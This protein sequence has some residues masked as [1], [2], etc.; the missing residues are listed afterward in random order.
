[1][2]PKGRFLNL[3]IKMSITY[4]IFQGVNTW[5]NQMKVQKRI[6]T[7]NKFKMHKES[8]IIDMGANKITI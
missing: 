4:L 2:L 8:F 7:N 1:M 6:Y 3:F 5:K